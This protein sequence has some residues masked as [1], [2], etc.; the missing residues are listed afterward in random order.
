MD[1]GASRPHQGAQDL[2]GPGPPWVRG[3]PAPITTQSTEETDAAAS[4]DKVRGGDPD[5][6]DPDLSDPDDAWRPAAVPLPEATAE[7]HGLRMPPMIRTR[8]DIGLPVSVSMRARA[9]SMADS[10]HVSGSGERNMP[11]DGWVPEQ[12]LL[13]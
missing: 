1:R 5:Q 11:R 3:R 9:P 10:G 12:N 6:R 8:A 2:H 4:L 7:D 13:V